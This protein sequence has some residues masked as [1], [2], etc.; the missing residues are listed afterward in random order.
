M[1][2]CV[3]NRFTFP[4][5]SAQNKWSMT[6]LAYARQADFIPQPWCRGQG[7]NSLFEAGDTQ[8]NYGGPQP[9]NSRCALGFVRWR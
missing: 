9:P 7:H 1:L 4:N 5:P 3:T 8:L 2:K 6:A